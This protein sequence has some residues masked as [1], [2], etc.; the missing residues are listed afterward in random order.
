MARVIVCVAVLAFSAWWLAFAGCTRFDRSNGTSTHEDGPIVEPLQG[1]ILVTVDTLRADHLPSYG[2]PRAI[3]PFLSRL[4]EEGVLFERAIS[5]CSHT[6][7]SHASL[8]TGLHPP[9]HRLLENGQRL[10]DRFSTVAEQLAHL[11][12]RTAAVTTAKFL[13]GVSRGFEDFITPQ[14]AFGNASWIV[15]EGLDWLDELESGTPF[16]LWLHF[17]DVHEWDDA[18]RLDV[19]AARELEV[20]AGPHGRE[21]VDYLVREQGD[22]LQYLRSERELLD[23]VN[24]YDGQILAVDR[25]LGRFER[26]LA[27]SA[28]GS[29][30]AWIV[31]SDHG[32][33]LG[34]HGHKGH[35]KNIYDE[36]LRVPL[37]FH[38]PDARWQPGR[39][40]A[41]VQLI[42]LAPT[43]LD[44]VGIPYEVEGYEL[45]ARSLTPLL[46]GDAKAWRDRF[47]FAMRRPADDFRLG[48]GWAPG[49]VFS[50]QEGPMKVIVHTEGTVEL[51]D[52]S[53]DPYEQDDLA[54][55][56][57]GVRRLSQERA[58]YV[59]SR[60]HSHSET[61]EDRGIDP[62]HVEELRA[63]GYL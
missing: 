29:K 2:Y 45:L 50:L 62:E 17:F 55:D 13:K 22:P 20:L 41:L 7:P 12:Y 8:F 37:V 57:T 42:D 26:R 1:F 5:S 19:A 11:G 36:Q 24:A 27:E 63:L 31:T 21:L 28:F 32:E 14:A 33:G 9:Q 58:T 46:S 3:T 44:L 6:S 48:R 61:L 43:L 23:M 52:L 4:A 47:A 25:E 59:F 38:A 34:N 35:G 60:L 10:N 18:S 39:V 40:G 49:D 51:Y 53:E 30:T 15:D 56:R 16:F 54:G